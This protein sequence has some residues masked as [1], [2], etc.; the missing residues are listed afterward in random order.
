MSG[1]TEERMLAASASS[2]SISSDT[3]R[4]SGGAGKL[5]RALVVVVVVV[6]VVCTW[7]C[8]FVCVSWSSEEEWPSS[9]SSVLQ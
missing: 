7:W 4:F 1:K 5:P 6:V 2:V 8:V 9:S 3:A